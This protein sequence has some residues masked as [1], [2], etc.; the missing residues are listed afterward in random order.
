MERGMGEFL[1]HFILVNLI[2]LILEKMV[3]ELL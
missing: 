1:Y 3:D 2:L